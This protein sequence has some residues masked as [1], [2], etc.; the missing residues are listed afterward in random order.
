M[1][2]HEKYITDAVNASEAGGVVH[3]VELNEENR[4]VSDP[5]SRPRSERRSMVGEPP[6][7]ETAVR[8]ESKP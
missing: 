6:A 1:E 2:A 4:I 3:K 8:D 5:S 7:P